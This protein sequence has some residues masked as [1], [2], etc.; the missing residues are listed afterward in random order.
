MIYVYLLVGLIA[1]Y[2]VAYLAHAHNPAKKA[3]EKALAK[4]QEEFGHYQNQVAVHFQKTAELV[5]ALQVQ[6]D[7]I[8]SHLTEGAKSLR[9]TVLLEILDP[10]EI[11]EEKSAPRDY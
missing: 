3:L 8:I 7:N 6:Q 11:L 1:G 5:E 10:T 9:P 4:K 2:A